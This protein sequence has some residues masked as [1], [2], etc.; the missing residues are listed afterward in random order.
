MDSDLIIIIGAGFLLLIILVVGFY[1]YYKFSR[2]AAIAKWK[3][4][5][6]DKVK[7]ILEVKKEFEEKGKGN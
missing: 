2:E 4:N 3:V 1:F 6:P 7:K 5:N